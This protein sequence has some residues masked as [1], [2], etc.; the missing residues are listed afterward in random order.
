MI[1]SAADGC[2]PLLAELR[3][4]F[5]HALRVVHA[6]TAASPSPATSPSSH[7]AT[8]SSGDADM[9]SASHSAAAAEASSQSLA[10][11]VSSPSASASASAAVEYLPPIEIKD[12][13]TEVFLRYLPRLVR[14]DIRC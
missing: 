3:P 13:V 8:D 11:A 7:A 9:A 14:C 12:E 5:E 1:L 4:F 2:G 10:E 6:A